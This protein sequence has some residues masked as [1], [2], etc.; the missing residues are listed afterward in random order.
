[1]NSIHLTLFSAMTVYLLTACGADSL[2]GPADPGSKGNVINSMEIE[3]S[4]APDSNGV[5]PI[6]ASIDNG[7]FILKWDVTTSNPYDYFVSVSSDASYEMDHEFFS[8]VCGGSSACKS[9]VTF[10][11]NMTN[12]EGDIKL[13]L[14][15]SGDG[16][17]SL[18]ANY[19]LNHIV[20]QICHFSSGDCTDQAIK[21]YFATE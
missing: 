21:V 14:A 17:V 10:A 12:N 5:V 8:G 9:T 6:L 2:S 13:D 3:G 1:M 19:S 11:C 4:A 15:C 16:A 7:S 20:L 18:S